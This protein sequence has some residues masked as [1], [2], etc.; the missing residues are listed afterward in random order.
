MK[1]LRSLET[2]EEKKQL[3]LEMDDEYFVDDLLKFEE[4]D[5]LKFEEP[6]STNKRYRSCKKITCELCNIKIS[7][8]LFGNHLISMYHYR[9]M[10]KKPD[11]SFETVLNN[12]HKIIAI[13]PFQC[14]MC[15]YY[16]NR[17]EDLLNHFKSQEHI[18]VLEGNRGKKLLSIYIWIEKVIIF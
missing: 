5:L 10:L 18:N 13:S 17:Q 16:F 11:K 7:T 6:D 2:L 4:P 15:K 1:K 14:S 8:Y 12:F 3:L 9:N